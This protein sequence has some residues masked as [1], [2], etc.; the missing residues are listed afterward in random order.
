M[1]LNYSKWDHIDVSDDE[2]DTHPNIDTPSLF[3]WRHQARLERMAENKQKQEEIESN[4][5]KNETK[6]KELSAKLQKTD[7]SSEEKNKVE[8][9]LSDVKKQEE[10]WLK[11][12]KDLEEKLR[13]EP[14]NIDTIGHEAFS[15]SRINKYSDKK[16]PE[17]KQMDSE[18]VYES[19][20]K[21]INKHESELSTYCHLKDLSASRDYLIEHPHLVN[22][23]AA[24]FI[25]LEALNYAI[26]EEEE[27]LVT[28]SK[29][30][31]II[32]YII[33]IAKQLKTKPDHPNVV[34]NFFT[35]FEKADVAYMKL[36]NDEVAQFQDRLRKRAKVKIE[37]A[38]QEEE[39]EEKAERIRN[40]PGGLDPL[41][42][43]AALPVEMKEAFQSQD[44]AALEALVTTM[45][46]E[47]FSY[48]FDRCIKSGLWVPSTEDKENSESEQNQ[49][50]ST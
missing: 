15:S 21:F 37:E 18:E 26:K 16:E 45:D 33:E 46:R 44:V 47:V 48:H 36:Y 28:L 1:S 12:E 49:T 11:K 25:T 27:N 30:G 7:I 4:R 9:E 3:R 17:P 41:E 43:L 32:Q 24:D 38:R 8:K 31:I 23:Y 34:R 5:K 40:S 39:E 29:Q 35:K 42:V 10:E 2:D 6:V 19:M 50:E 22:N 13:N 14:W 20:S